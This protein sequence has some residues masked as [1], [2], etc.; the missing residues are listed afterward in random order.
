MDWIHFHTSNNIRCPYCTDGVS[1]RPMARQG[2]GDW[3]V[4]QGC[5]HLS[6]PSSP[7]YRC[8]CSKCSALEK[9]IGIHPGVT[10]PVVALPPRVQSVAFY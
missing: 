6:L 7:V 2:S 4:C 5:G 3:Y 9:K 10:F 1:F 8:T